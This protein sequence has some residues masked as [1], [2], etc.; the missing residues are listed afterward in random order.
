[1]PS[2]LSKL[3]FKVAGKLPP[4]WIL[5]YLRMTKAQ[6]FAI[7][8]SLVGFF[9][10]VKQL[11]FTKR[12]SRRRSKGYGGLG[13]GPKKTTPGINIE[14]FKQMRF[15][16]K[17]MIPTLWSKQIAI[18]LAHTGMLMARTFLSIY[19][20][21]LEGKIVREIVQKNVGQF[22]RLLTKWLVIAI[23]ACFCNSSI[24]FL[25]KHLALSLRTSLVNQ[26]YKTYFSN[27]I[28]YK[29]GN[30]DTRIPNP[31]HSLTEDISEFTTSVAHLYSHI[32]KP[33]FDC[34]MVSLTL[35]QRSQ[36]VGSNLFLGPFIT[37]SVVGLTGQILKA[38]SPRF[39]QLAAKEAETKAKLRH[40]HSRI[41]TNSEEIA[42]YGG[43]E[44]EKNILQDAYRQEYQ[45]SK[46]IYFSKLW[47]V[48][49]EQFLMKYC[50]GGTG[51]VVTAIPILTAHSL[52]NGS[53]AAKRTEYYMTSKHLLVSGADAMERLMTSYKEAVELAGYSS[54]VANIFKVFDEVSK[55]IYIRESCIERDIQIGT[56]VENNSSIIELTNIK[57]VTPT[58]DV[59]VQD[60]ELLIKPGMH[61]L[62]TGPNG[63]GK[64]SLFRILSGLWPVYGGHMTRPP[65]DRLYYIPQ[66]PYMSLGNLREQVIY[67][68]TRKDMHR[69]GMKDKD[70]TRILENVQLN[71]IVTREGGWDS[72][73]DWQDVLSGGEKQRVGIARLFYHKPTFA[74]LDEC[75]SAVS[76]DVED[77]MYQLMIKSG[78][79][80][81]TI[82]HRPS[83]FKHHTHILKFTGDGTW[84]FED[85]KL[86]S[87]S[88]TM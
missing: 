67:P 85:M 28:Y 56:V 76:M 26:A 16:L 41:V 34:L 15:L 64:S 83:L 6:K 22:I 42:F 80:L 47:Y 19:V 21:K 5:L 79:T 24:R 7:L 52:K 54:R 39:G 70:L 13:V 73:R 20:A 30:L 36:A 53:G 29:V 81:L 12:K 40:K 69:K 58:G 65:V 18:L 71:H 35:F 3:T 46:K 61:L 2:T 44:V 51:M 27:Q 72:V 87:S 11:Y 86:E 88:W 59:I 75:T 49:F 1:M 43:G 48:F 55:G 37:L 25:E 14:F 32:T 38:I 82:T 57:V 9:G 77:S 60:L 17:L 23:P 63:C 45:Q 62:I 4:E 31:D 78:I 33:L 8:G 84:S 10:V 68:D 50:W 66:R 74:L